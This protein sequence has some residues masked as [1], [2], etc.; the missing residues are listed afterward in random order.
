MYNLEVDGN[1]DFFVGEKSWLVHNCD[2]LEGAN[3]AQR[4]FTRS[5]SDA[6]KFAGKTV[7]EVASMLK[8]GT[9]KPNDLPI[10]YIVRDGNVLILNTRSSQALTQAGISRSEWLGIERTGQ[11][12]YESRLTGQLRRNGLS[13]IGTPS[14]KPTGR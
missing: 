14:V 3:F 1:H 13:N 4:T 9:L 8:L 11:A 12:A 5:F 7:D 10:D 2:A 6:G